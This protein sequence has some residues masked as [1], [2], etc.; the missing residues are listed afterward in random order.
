M[1]STNPFSERYARTV[2][3]ILS[4]ISAVGL[5]EILQIRMRDHCSV[6]DS[7]RQAAKATVLATRHR[8]R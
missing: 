5:A 8:A 6:I 4:R 1:D 3:S 7:V 2:Q